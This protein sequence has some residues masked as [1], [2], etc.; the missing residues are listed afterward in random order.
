MSLNTYTFIHHKKQAGFGLP[1]AIFIITVLAMVAAGISKLGETSAVAFGQDIHSIK[2][3]YAAESGAQIGLA[4]LFSIVS[5]SVPADQLCVPSVSI[6]SNHSALEGLNKC[7]V[8]VVCSSV[9]NLPDT[10][11]TLVSTATCGSGID[12]AQRIVE[13][14]AKS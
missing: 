12:A 4:R 14:K 11:Y 5:P 3:F 7:D 9:T 2:A 10:Y 6:Y 8:D 13:V 1:V